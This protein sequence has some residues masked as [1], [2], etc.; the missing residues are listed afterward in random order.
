[1]RRKAEALAREMADG[2]PQDI[3]AREALEE[4][5]STIGNALGT[6]AEPDADT[7]TPNLGDIIDSEEL[8]SLMENFHKI[9]QIG[10]AILDIS[11]NVLVG[12]AWKDICTKF[13][14]AHPETA[15]NCLESDLALAKGL[16]AGTFKAYRCKN[17]MWDMVSPIKVGEKHLGNIYIG[18]FFYEDE[19]VDREL[20]EKQARRY[21]FDETEYLAA[22]DRVPRLKR[23][24]VES[25][26][27]FYAKLAGMISSLSYG[28]IKL[29]R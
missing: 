11:G 1:M 16:P 12:V 29:S 14:R 20:F 2:T 27:T 13:H 22:L 8:Q 5:E 4:S 7:G 10:G 26:M 28:K 15:K 24:T 9:T 18:Q 17:N 21:G 25:A 6:I 19:D 23:E 3:A